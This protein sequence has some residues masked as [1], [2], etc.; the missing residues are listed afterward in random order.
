MDAGVVE[1]SAQMNPSYELGTGESSFEP[2]V[3]G[4]DLFFA[5]GPQGGCHFW[6]GVRTTGFPSRGTK[7]RYEVVY[8]DTGT[9]TMSRS[10]FAIAL[11][12]V[13]GEEVCESF[14]LTGFLIQPWKFEDARVEIRTEVW[15]EPTSTT[16]VSATASKTVMARWPGDDP[17][18]CGSR[19]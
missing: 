9:T 6:L 11:E 2:L 13:D 4:Q 1:C 5:P 7:L 8:A 10:S 17:N 14:G 3:D 18:L 19:S 16:K 15:Y 12:P